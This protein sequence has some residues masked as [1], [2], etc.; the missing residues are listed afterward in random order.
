MSVALWIS[1]LLGQVSEGIW[2][3]FLCSHDWRL[4]QV[5]CLAINLDITLFK[6]L[7][8][9]ISFKKYFSCLFL[10]SFLFRPIANFETEGSLNTQRCES[11]ASEV[12]IEEWFRL[13]VNDIMIEEQQRIRKGKQILRNAV[14]AWCSVSP[15]HFLP[16]LW[17]SKDG[18][19]YDTSLT[20]TWIQDPG[21]LGA[22][23]FLMYKGGLESPIFHYCQS[24]SW[25]YM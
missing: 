10:F 24:P 5:T 1:K 11:L 7:T 20:C 2:G 17:V 14:K 21:G 22:L 8:Q 15:G 19:S 13:S 18:L 25:D 12:R 4:H 3:F 23:G 16:V 9:N 6:H